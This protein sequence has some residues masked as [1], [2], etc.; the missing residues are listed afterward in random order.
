MSPLRTFALCLVMG[1]AASLWAARLPPAAAQEGFEPPPPRAAPRASVMAE[2]LPRAGGI[3]VFGADAPL[4]LA[5]ARTL[6][7]LGKQVIAAV[8]AGA[9]TAA[10]AALK[11]QVVTVD[12]RDPDAVK[13]A[14]SSVPLRAVVA[15]YAAAGGGEDLALDGTRNIVAATAAAGVPRFVLVSP[16]GAGDSVSALPW[17]VRLLRGGALPGANAAEA[18]VRDSGLEYTIVRAGWILGGAPDGGAPDGG[19]VT[20]D[21]GEPAFSWI[22]NGDLAR[23]VASVVD[24][25]SMAG[26][27][28]TAFDPART[29]LFSAIF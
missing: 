27:T 10:L 24:A 6:A 13:E 3:I 19:A 21:E 17:Y 2:E 25:K 18:H 12:P 29:S 20:L 1:L 26:K 16:T 23:L 7:G 5:I 11:A 28:A 14:F 8:P 9:D 22:G 15:P 4:G